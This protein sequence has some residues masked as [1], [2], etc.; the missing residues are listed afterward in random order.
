MD[1]LMID[2]EKLYLLYWKQAA[3]DFG[4]TMLDQHVF[5]IRSL[6]RQFSI[7]KLK[8]FFGE[9]FPTEDI[10]ER[11][12][13][14]INAHIAEHGIEV[15]K[16]LYELIGFLRSKGIKTAVATA[17]PRERTLMYLEKINILSCIDAV[18]CGDMVKT[19]KPAPDIYLTAAAE[20]GLS[21]GECAAFEDSPN[22]IKAAYSAGCHAIM[23]PDLTPPD[24]EIAPMLSGIY[25]N[26]SDA[27]EYFLVAE[28]P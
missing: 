27:A 15:K 7:P 11:R 2:T 25:S 21:A 5:A 23:I 24:D 8:G 18:V 20:L 13:E 4:Y 10:R 19:G 1:G 9:D 3:A 22:G 28:L 17:T 12:T 26:L 14:L 6:A 16:G